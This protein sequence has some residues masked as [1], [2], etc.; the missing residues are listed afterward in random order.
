MTNPLPS[1]TQLVIPPTFTVDGALPPGR[2]LS[3]VDGVRTR[4]VEP[5]PA[6]STRR[7]LYDAWRVRRQTLF[8]IVQVEM[9]WVNGSFVTAKH[10]PNDIDVT[11]FITDDNMAAVSVDQRQAV[12]D[13]TAG[14]APQQVGC[15]SFLVIVF[16]DNHP[17]RVAYLQQRGYWDDW[18]SRRRTGQEKGYIDVRGQA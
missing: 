1:T 5:F 18:W 15:H 2:H 4:L 7:S 17:Y 3:D 10:A 14:P 9:E 11:T 16:P 6:S 8:G 13:L 12:W